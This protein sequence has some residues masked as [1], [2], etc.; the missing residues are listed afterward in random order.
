MF[1]T[2]D[3]TPGE[4]IIYIPDITLNSIPVDNDI[5]ADS[6]EIDVVLSMCYTGDDFVDA[7]DGDVE[8]AKELFDFCD[9]QHPS[10]AATDMATWDDDI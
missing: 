5:S 7:A 9:W 3:F 10:S 6:D 1:K 4:E 8:K 2:D